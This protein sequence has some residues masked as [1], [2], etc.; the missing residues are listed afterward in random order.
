MVV[1]SGTIVQVF[2]LKSAPKYNGTRGIIMSRG[3]SDNSGV[4][5]YPI[6]LFNHN[7]IIIAARCSNFKP[8]RDAKEWIVPPLQQ[9]ILELVKTK[10]NY[11][12]NEE[13]CHIFTKKVWGELS[14]TIPALQLNIS[15]KSPDFITVAGHKLFWLELDAIGHHL[16][17][18]KC[19]GSWRV[20]QSHIKTRS[21]GYTANEWCFGDMRGK[22]AWEK[23]GGGKMMSDGDLSELMDTI[24][25]C[26]CVVKK[27]LNTVLLDSVPNIDPETIACLK[28]TPRNIKDPMMLRRCNDAIVLIERWG[29]SLM[30]RIQGPEGCTLIGFDYITQ[31]VEPMSSHIDV[32]I[33]SDLIFHIPKKLY[34]KC[35]ALYNALTGEIIEGPPFIM[36]I[37]FGVW[38]EFIRDPDTGGAVGFGFRAMDMDME[39][40]MAERLERAEMLTKTIRNIA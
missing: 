32:Y 25:E 4:I 34:E 16:L 23:Y 24:S 22:K 17:L 11:L 39:K 2:G 8:C 15:K 21:V 18:E 7:G 28:K 6:R 20:F 30:R 13:Y 27:L 33:G 19:K 14:E 38:W 10:G 31:R 37:R 36:M 1:P 29:S 35:Y 40:S 26:Q 5:R 3:T 9:S 12:G